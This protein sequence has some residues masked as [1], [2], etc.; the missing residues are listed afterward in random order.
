MQEKLM[1][2]QRIYDDLIKRAKKRPRPEG[3]V[4]CHHI[5]PTSLGGTDDRSNLVY[6]T[7]REHFIAHKLLIKITTGN[8]RRK[9]V[10]AFAYMA[11]TKDN[12]FHKRQCSSRDYE[13]ARRLFREQGF[14]EERNRK[15]SEA[16]RR[17]FAS[18]FK[19]VRSDATKVTHRATLAAKK[20]AGIRMAQHQRDAIREGLKGNTN[21]AGHVVTEAHRKIIAA[22][23]SSTYEV[24]FPD[25]HTETVN[26]LSEWLRQRNHTKGFPIVDRPIKKGLWAGFTFKRLS[27]RF[28]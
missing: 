3:Y 1:N 20:A 17:L 25:G 6:L 10:N 2:Y 18:G 14:T 4:E 26:N 15:I 5:M 13:L 24:T 28:L 9:M 12:R 16:R 8:S 22:S 19:Q 27:S 11:F 7:A 21:G 23:T